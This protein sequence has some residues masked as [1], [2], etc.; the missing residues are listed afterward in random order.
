MEITVLGCGT[1]IPNPKK[2]GSSFFIKDGK[3]SVLLD[4]GPN[5]LRNL[6]KAE[7]DRFK[8]NNIV[9]SHFHLDHFSDLLV[10]LFNRAYTIG[11]VKEQK[12]I[13]LNIYGPKNAPKFKDKVLVNLRGISIRDVLNS[14]K[15]KNIERKNLKIGGFK[16]EALPVKHFGLNAMA[17]RLEKNGKIVAYT[18]DTA[19]CKNLTPI[20]KDADLAIMQCALSKKKAEENGHLNS[21]DVG[22]IAQEAGVKTVILTHLYPDA[23]KTDIKREVKENFKGKVILARDLLKIKV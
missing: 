10:Y 22:R 5:S 4:M 19:T 1:N 6:V 15:I 8:I 13:P 12:I 3:D 23:E 9:I 17:V 14:F 7:I 16:V 21:E 20:L 2:A 18:G 11:H